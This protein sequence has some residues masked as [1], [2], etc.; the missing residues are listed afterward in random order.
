[1]SD[2]FMWF[3]ILIGSS[4]S[5]GWI[6]FYVFCFF[7]FS[8]FAVLYFL[9]LFKKTKEENILIKFIGFIFNGVCSIFM[10]FVLYYNFIHLMK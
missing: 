4:Y 10:G 2:I 5:I 1:M 3:T 8:Y 7:I 9:R 6:L